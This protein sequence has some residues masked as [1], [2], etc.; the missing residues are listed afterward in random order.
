MKKLYLLLLLALTPLLL[1]SS[2]INFSQVGNLGGFQGTSWADCSSD[3]T[4]NSSG[5]GT[6]TNK[7]LF[8]RRVGDTLE[9]Q[10]SFKAGTVNTGEGYLSFTKWA[11]DTSKISGSS[12]AYL[13]PATEIRT[14][15]AG[16]HP[17]YLWFSDGTTTDRFWLSY[18]SSSNAFGKNSVSNILAT[19]D[20][21][22]VNVSFPVA[23][24]GVSGPSTGGTRIFSVAFGGATEGTNNC[25]GSPCTI[26]RQNDSLGQ[27]STVS[28][29]TRSGTG[30]YTINITAGRCTTAPVCTASM[31]QS[32]R[33]PLFS[34][35]P[36]TTAVALDSNDGSSAADGAFNVIC[37]CSS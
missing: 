37:S 3:L 35:A 8:C 1:G 7:S 34:T 5:Y 12:T 25:S 22:N 20:L 32:L 31:R 33:Y 15:G 16:T 21:V 17:N 4:P 11:I 6:V 28:S 9:I 24:W 19:N 13:G 10:G 18:Q 14:G 30:A 2:A 23:G 27:S 26:Y 36:T 29:V